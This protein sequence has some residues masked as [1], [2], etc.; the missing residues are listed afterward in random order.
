MLFALLGLSR[1]GCDNFIQA[2]EH[3]FLFAAG[4]APPLHS[5]HTHAPVKPAHSVPFIQPSCA[6]PPLQELLLTFPCRCSCVPAPAI[7]QTEPGFL[8]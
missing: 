2:P 7:N 6:A 5:P 1:A 4:A 3:C 8:G